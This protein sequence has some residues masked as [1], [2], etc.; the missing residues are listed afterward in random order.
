MLIPILKMRAAYLN[1]IIEKAG[2]IIR[3]SHPESNRCK[4]AKADQHAAKAC[5]AEL[6]TIEQEYRKIKDYPF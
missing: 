3:S 6:I 1:S 4:A 5:I 2:H